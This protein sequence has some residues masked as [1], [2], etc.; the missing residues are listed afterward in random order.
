M[1]PNQIERLGMMAMVGGQRAVVETMEDLNNDILGAADKG[2]TLAL[3][4]PRTPE[5]LAVAVAWGFA[6]PE[7][8]DKYDRFLRGQ[9]LCVEVKTP[10]EW[11]VVRTDHWLYKNVL[12]PAGQVRASLMVHYQDHDAWFRVTPKYR[13]TTWQANHGDD[14]PVWPVIQ[15]SNGNVLWVGHRVEVAP[16]HMEKYKQ[17]WADCR[18]KG[19]E[20]AEAERKA[21][22]SPNQKAARTAEMVLTRDLKVDPWDQKW[23]D[24]PFQ[25]PGSVGVLPAVQTYSLRTEYYHGAGGNYADGGS[26]EIKAE[27]DEKAIAIAKARFSQPGG[28]HRK[29]W[30]MDQA[31]KPLWR[32]EDQQPRRR[33]EDLDPRGHWFTTNYYGK[34]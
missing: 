24:E 27:D 29:A 32:Y 3:P 33:R 8:Q 21:P 22:L 7:G 23:F 18:A 26:S 4:R 17:H 14:E 20:H 16:Q 6:W 19:V 10:A 28:Y 12:D 34:R 9:E 31:G 25:F 30:L 1:K 11:S 2:G 13:A 5:D 15:D